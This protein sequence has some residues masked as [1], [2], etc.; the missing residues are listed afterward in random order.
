MIFLLFF[1]VS[2]LLI[3]GASIYLGLRIVHTRLPRM[4]NML[5]FG[6]ECGV[7]WLSILPVANI[8]FLVFVVLLTVILKRF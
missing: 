1:S 3:A 5:K 4:T 7:I 6:I 2:W 8:I